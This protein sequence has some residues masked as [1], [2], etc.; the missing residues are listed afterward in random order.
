MKRLLCV[1]VAVALSYVSVFTAF[2]QSVCESFRRGDV[3]CD[4]YITIIDA[5]VIQKG[6]SALV[7][8][9]ET[10]QTLADVNGNGLV[11]IIDATFI[12]QYI[13]QIIDEF[14]PEFQD[15][16]VPVYWREHLHSKAEQI[17]TT[18]KSVSENHCAFFWYNDSHWS[19]NSKS[20]PYLLRFLNRHTDI[21]KTNYGGDIVNIEADITTP[22]GLQTMEY[23]NEWRSMIKDIPNHHSIIGNHDDG[24]K[25]NNLFPDEYIYSFLLKPEESEDIVRGDGFYYYIDN[26]KEKTRYIYL[27]SAYRGATAQQLEF[28]ENALLTAKD[29][30]HF[31]VFSHIWYN[32][33]YS[34][35]DVRPIPITG[36]NKNATQFLFVLDSYNRR[37]GQFADCTGRVEF[38]IGGHAHVDYSGYSDFGIPIIITEA[39]CIN[40]RSAYSSA[41]KTTNESSINAVVADFDKREINII[42]VGRGENKTI[43][44]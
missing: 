11:D 20:S 32:P 12:Q 25:T 18:M 22:E 13:A 28:L 9:G 39:D 36:L 27:D 7:V 31:V 30:Y 44:Y 38:C 35:Y 42:R 26:E 4:D 6:V 14:P 10:Q 5:T 21:D 29:N 23:L 15:T 37:L 34:Q 43:K 8:M 3:D 1:F 17:N 16:Y 24:N 40:E 2:S 33:D 19:Y 41:L